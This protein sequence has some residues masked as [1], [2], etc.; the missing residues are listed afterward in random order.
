[1]DNWW[2]IVGQLKSKLDVIYAFDT[3]GLLIYGDC[4]I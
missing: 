3:L 4:N 1:M 2:V